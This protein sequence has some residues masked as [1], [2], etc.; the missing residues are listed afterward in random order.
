[1]W[2]LYKYQ[3]ITEQTLGNLARRKLWAS[4]PSA[5]SDPFEFRLQRVANPPGIAEL[6]TQNPHLDSLSDAEFLDGAITEFERTI[7][8][9]G[10]VCFAQEPNETL[11]WSHYADRHRGMCLGFSGETALEE[12]AVYPV[13]YSD[14]YPEL[15]FKQIWHRNGLARVLWTKH[16]KWSY[17]KEFRLIRIEGNQLIDYPGSLTRVIFGLRTSASDQQ[18]IR[19]VLATESAVE[20]FKVVQDPAAYEL[21]VVAN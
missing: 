17:E 9:S 14:D 8:S 18:A 6:R 15:T 12:V 13:E 20:Y 2:R 3:P 21:H 4:C 5:F 7:S 1:M 10:V 16:S 11:M 19:K